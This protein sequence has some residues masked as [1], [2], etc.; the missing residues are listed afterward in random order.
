[1]NFVILETLLDTFD[2]RKNLVL[3]MVN[4]A[5]RIEWRIE[6]PKNQKNE[7]ITSMIP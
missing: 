3:R 4:Q 5:L 7:L 6:S 1:M 2:S